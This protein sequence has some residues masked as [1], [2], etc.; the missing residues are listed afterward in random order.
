MFVYQTIAL[1]LIILTTLMWIRIAS[2]NE[3]TLEVLKHGWYIILFAMF[4]SSI[5]GYVLKFAVSVF[6]C[7][8]SFQVW[9]KVD[10]IKFKE[11]F[12]LLSVN[13]QPKKYALIQFTEMLAFTICFV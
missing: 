12:Q 11:L 10:W 6:K 4:I 7:L 5:G 1:I 9:F 3:N 8:A 2:N 13:F